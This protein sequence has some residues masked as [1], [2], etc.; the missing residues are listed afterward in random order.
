M[1]FHQTG[2]IFNDVLRERPE[3]PVIFHSRCSLFQKTLGVLIGRLYKTRLQSY[4]ASCCYY[5]FF[6]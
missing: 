6:Y 5:Y 3:D 2:F 1:D 4:A